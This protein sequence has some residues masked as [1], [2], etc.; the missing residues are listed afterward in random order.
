MKPIRVL[1]ENV[2]MDQGGIENLIMNIYRNIDRDKIQFDFLVHRSKKGCFDNEIRELGGKIYVTPPFNPLRHYQYI[3]GI[4]GVLLNHPEYKIIHCHSELNMWPLRIAA[5]AGIPVRIAHSH[6]SKTSVD[7]K[8]FFMKYQQLTIKKY[9]THMFMCSEEAGKWAF[10]DKGIKSENAYIVKNGIE[11][12]KFGYDPAIRKTVRAEF[13][14]ENK[15]VIGHVGRFMKQK[16][17]T[18]LIDIFDEVLKRRSDAVLFLVGEGELEDEIRNKVK[19]LNIEKNVIFTGAR[20]DVNRLYQAMDV[21]VFPSLWEGLGIVLLEAQ[22]AGLLCFISDVVPKDSYVTNNLNYLPLRDSKL[23]A[24]KISAVNITKRNSYVSDV[25]KAG[26]DIKSTVD[27][28]SEFYMN[29]VK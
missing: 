9:C 26:F 21:F 18:F 17:H 27:F 23:W 19:R 29:Y 28:L 1:H 25:A 24:D 7:L 22:T 5:K 20:N 8:Y 4:R 16:N 3:N 14:I 6:N 15:F 10:G 13:G 11:A 12:D 2:I